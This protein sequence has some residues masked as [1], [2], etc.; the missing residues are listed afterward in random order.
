MKREAF[1]NLMDS[2]S[3][4]VKASGKRALTG[5]E[6]ADDYVTPKPAIRIPKPRTPNKTEA[7]FMSFAADRWPGADV[8]YEPITLRLPSGCSYTPDF[9]IHRNGGWTGF[10]EVKGPHI[11]NQRSIHAFKEAR[12]AFPMF[13]WIFAQWKDG[14]WALAELP[15]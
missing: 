4:T 12:A 13:R 15:Q 2:A 9:M 7:R 6:L 3:P 8:R 5:R 10:I 11:R 14:D 1:N